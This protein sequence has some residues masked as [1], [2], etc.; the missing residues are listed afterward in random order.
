MRF[1]NEH[2]KLIHLDLTIQCFN[3]SKFIHMTSTRK[4]ILL[5]FRLP[6]CRLSLN[7]NTHSGIV[8]LKETNGMCYG[9][10]KQT[11]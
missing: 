6:M 11:L 3:I 10:Y 4:I 2:A 5:Q 7:S 9:M 1:F 8:Q